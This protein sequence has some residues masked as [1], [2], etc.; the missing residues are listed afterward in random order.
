M[1]I[2]VIGGRDFNGDDRPN[3]P[4]VAIVNRAFATRYLSGRDPLTMQFKAGYPNLDLKTT[5]TIIG[6]VDDVRQ[7]SLSVAAEPAYY[8]SHGQGTPHRQAVVVHAAAGDSEA[9]RS[10]IRA[11]VRKIDPQIPSNSSAWRIS[12]A[13]RSAAR[14]S[15]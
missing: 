12:S 15:A 14:N 13:R 6:V 4:R 8:T 9:L 2:Q 5:W 11:E 7:R 1:G 3:T 10:A